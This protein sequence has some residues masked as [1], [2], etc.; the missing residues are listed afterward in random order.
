LQRDKDAEVARLVPDRT[1]RRNAPEPALTI[2][3]WR[4]TNHLLAE[5]RKTRQ[6]TIEFA[7]TTKSD[8]RSYCF[9]HS[10]FGDLDCYQWL[11]ALSLHG[12]RHAG[13]IE[14]IKACKGYPRN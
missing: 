1:T 14:E 3:E 9:P 6:S 10:L 4:D 13:Q 2:G 7:D 12:D 11:L 5:F 8:L